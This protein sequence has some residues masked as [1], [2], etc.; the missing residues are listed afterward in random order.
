MK[1]KKPFGDDTPKKHR[2]LQPAWKP[3]QS[4]NPA[5][6][7][8]GSRSKFNEAFLADFIAAWEQLGPEALTRTAAESP[9]VFVRVAAS[10][11][12]RH[13]KMEHDFGELTDEQLD[14]YISDLNSAIAQELRASAGVAE[15]GTG[16]P[17]QGTRH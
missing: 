2:N 12:P 10:L 3:G 14:K 13:F 17:P 5:G 11:L 7:P 9:G 6:R 15:G 1:P 8:K 4:G 16:T